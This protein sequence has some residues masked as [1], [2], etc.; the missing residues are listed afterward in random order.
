[1]LA[2]M[3]HDSESGTGVADDTSTVADARAPVRLVGHVRQPGRRSARGGRAAGRRARDAR[4]P[5]QPERHAK[6]CGRAPGTALGGCQ[7]NVST[8]VLLAT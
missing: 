3:T 7:S 4:A 2:S 5:G 8:R 1:M 6:E